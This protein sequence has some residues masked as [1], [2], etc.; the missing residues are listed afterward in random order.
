ME[1]EVF[2]VEPQFLHV[3]FY[4]QAFSQCSSILISEILMC[5]LGHVHVFLAHLNKHL[6]FQ[7]S[8]E[9]T[10]SMTVYFD[11]GIMLLST[12]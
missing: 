2:H 5:F 4:F 8:N 9:S 7:L 11:R 3:V 10:A 1:S 6:V 12:Y